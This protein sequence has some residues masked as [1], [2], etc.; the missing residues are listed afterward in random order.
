MPLL[1]SKMDEIFEELERTE[2]P[3]SDAVL[4]PLFE[5]HGYHLYQNF[6]KFDENSRRYI[7][8]GNIKIR[9]GESMVRR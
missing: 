6:V 2:A 1:D 8:M 7:E 4:L 9:I 3:R 5:E